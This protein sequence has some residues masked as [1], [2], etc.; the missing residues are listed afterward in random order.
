MFSFPTQQ[1]RDNCS[2][3]VLDNKVFVSGGISES[4]SLDSVECFCPELNKWET[5]STMPNKIYRYDELNIIHDTE[6]ARFP[7]LIS[8]NA[9][10]ANRFIVTVAL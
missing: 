2:V 7:W 9:E 4:N 5:V 3:T 1:K 6:S 10:P 8:T